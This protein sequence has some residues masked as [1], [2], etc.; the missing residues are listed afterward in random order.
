MYTCIKDPETGR[1][2]YVD[3]SLTRRTVYVPGGHSLSRIQR[4]VARDVVTETDLVETILDELRG[5]VIK[6]G[7][8]LASILREVFGICTESCPDLLAAVEERLNVAMLEGAV[9]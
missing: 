9:L 1:R 5:V 6:N 8:L 2:L 3:I 4:V 7:V